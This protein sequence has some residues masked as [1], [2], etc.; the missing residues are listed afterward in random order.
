MQEAFYCL[1]EKAFCQYPDVTYCMDI[2][3][4]LALAN[5]E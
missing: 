1:K 4:L 5:V 2:A 3:M